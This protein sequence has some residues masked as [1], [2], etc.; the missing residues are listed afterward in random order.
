MLVS[1]NKFLNYQ[2]LFYQN[3]YSLSS[4]TLLASQLRKE[5]KQL[6]KNRV[7]VICNKPFV[8]KKKDAMYSYRSIQL[9]NPF[10]YYLLVK[11]M[12]TESAWNEILT[13]FKKFSVPQIEVAGI[14][15]VK[16]ESDKSHQAAAV[17]FWW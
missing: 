7:C 10:L 6:E 17:S 1:K 4:L 12:T 9:S 11:K 5:R 2:N 13:R 16:S 15:K 8:A 3:S 14:P